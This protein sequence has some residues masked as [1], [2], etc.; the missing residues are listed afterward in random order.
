MKKPIT[1]AEAGA[2]ARYSEARE[3]CNELSNWL[4]RY[5]DLFREG[6]TLE[7]NI[8][9]AHTT[10]LRRMTELRDIYD[11]EIIREARANKTVMR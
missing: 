8:R 2:E 9:T 11:P 7:C 10:L 6:S 5:G 3:A 4:T 1:N